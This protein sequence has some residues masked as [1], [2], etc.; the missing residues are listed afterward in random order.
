MPLNTSQLIRNSKS[1]A[2]YKAILTLKT[3]SECAAFLR[4]LLTEDEI[5]EF[6][7]RWYVVEALDKGLSYREISKLTGL[8]TATITRV[9]KW[10]H[11]GTGGY[12]LTLGRVK[13]LHK[14]K[15]KPL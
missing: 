1:Q 8:S 12:Q 2:L 11:N 15:A 3:P 6:G 7:E 5:K 10:L 14:K 13:D 4:D 9:A